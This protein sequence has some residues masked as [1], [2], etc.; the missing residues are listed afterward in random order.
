MKSILSILLI[1]YSSFS[2]AKDLIRIGVSISN[3]PYAI[4]ESNSGYEIDLIKKVF[5]D[6]NYE[7]TFV[8]AT[9]AR[10]LIQFISGDL[11][12]IL[13]ANPDYIRQEYKRPIYMSEPIVT[14]KNYA[15]T[16]KKNSLKINSIEDLKNLR[17]NAFQ[18]ATSYLDESFKAMTRINKRYNEIPQ[19][20]NQPEYLLRDRADVIVAEKHIFTYYLHL[21]NAKI[22]R[23]ELF[24]FHPIFSPEDKSIIFKKELHQMEYNKRYQEL[25]KSGFVEK[26]RRLYS[27]EY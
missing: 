21:F 7:A 6:T 8:Y 2:L 3:P 19:Q 12:G 15:I 5:K 10:L 24:E 26:L 9:N 27:F 22:N 4:A 17:V 18:N 14:F 13:N 11:D 25:K 1:L 23:D 20:R 16:L